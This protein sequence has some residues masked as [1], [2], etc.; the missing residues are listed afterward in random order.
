MAT[1]SVEAVCKHYASVTAL[2]KVSIAF[3]ANRITALIG[4]S[5]CGKSTLLQMCNGLAR[6]DS[7][8]VVMFDQPIDYSALPALRRRIGYAVQGNGLFP[9]LTVRDNITLMAGVESWSEPAIEQRLK[10]LLELMQLQPGQLSQF[11]HQLSGG[12]QQRVGLCRAMM[13]G[14]ELL[15][16]DE[17]FA[18]ID[19]LTRLE[20][21]Q[22]LLALHRAEP[23]TT[24]LVTHDMQEALLLAD[25]IAVMVA[26]EILQIVD[27]TYLLEKYS[28][29]DPNQLL[30]SLMSGES[31]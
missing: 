28:G 27:K 9:H 20:I 12:Q 22:Q 15:L 10:Q 30:L 17:P 24:V 14:P 1:I 25:D 11:P 8:R 26:G 31:V 16:L 5:G 18:A 23:T 29:A 19:P 21:Q 13:L 7:G 3:A 2:D 6:P 4:R